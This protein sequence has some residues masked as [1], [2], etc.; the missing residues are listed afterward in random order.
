MIV[1]PRTKLQA[2]NLKQM[3][4]HGHGDATFRPLILEFKILPCY[5]NEERETVRVMEG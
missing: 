2:A 4:R 3:L 5:E 1:D